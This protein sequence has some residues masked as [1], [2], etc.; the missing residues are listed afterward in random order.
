MSKYLKQLTTDLPRW[1]G[2][3]YVSEPN[4]AL[5]IKD[6]EAQQ[7]E[8][9]FRLPLILSMLGGLLVFSGVI[10]WVAGNWDDLPRITRVAMLLGM[11][12]GSLGA[13]HH[14][15]AKGSEGLGQ[16]FAFLAA[17]MFGADIMLIAQIYQ[18][19]ANPPG[20]ALLWALGAIAVAVLWPSQLSMALAFAL[21]AIW[22]WFAGAVSSRGLFWDL[23]FTDNREL[24]MPFLPVWALL[25]AY[26]VKRGW[27]KALHVAGLALAFWCA[28]TLFAIF[29]DESA[30]VAGVALMVLV[31]LLTAG[32]H[33]LQV[34]RPGAG[35]VSKYLWTLFALWLLFVSAPEFYREM[36][37]HSE[38]VSPAI[39]LAALLAGAGAVYA[40]FSQPARFGNFLPVGAGLALAAAIGLM[41]N[42]GIFAGRDYYD[43]QYLSSP[44]GLQMFVSMVLISVAVMAAAVGSI[45]HGYRSN[46]RFFINLGFVLFAFKLIWLYFDDYWGLA[47]RAGFFVVG[48]LLVIAIGIVFDRQRRKLLARMK[49]GK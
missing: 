21:V 27:S 15:R 37:R 1:V 40:A 28:H 31:A 46:E 30:R 6:A 34:A 12:L 17:L 9:W 18:L 29:D 23:I 22:S 48:G 20:G 44:A 35:T 49:E 38:P 45:V 11:M 32:G 4:A 3:G 13:A 14:F 5:I 25:A 43:M 36:V 10:S 8:S 26:S 47:N 33:V 2:L 19:P 16:G 7:K 42:D 24:H 41:A 39:F